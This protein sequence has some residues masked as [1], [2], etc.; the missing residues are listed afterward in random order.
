MFDGTTIGGSDNAGT[1]LGIAGGISVSQIGQSVAVISSST[2]LVGPQAVVTT[3]IIDTYTVVANQAGLEIDGTSLSYPF[4]PVTQMITVG[5]VTM[6]QV[7]ST[8]LILE[9]TTYTIGDGSGSTTAVANAQSLTQASTASASVSTSL[10]TPVSP[11]PSVVN[12]ESPAQ[13]S[14]KSGGATVQLDNSLLAA[15]LVSFFAFT[16]YLI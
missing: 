12:P 5:D 3:V 1:E 2:L 10:R 16:K 8:L 6:T 15:C 11:Q 14:K 9:G 7:G 4:M 13:T